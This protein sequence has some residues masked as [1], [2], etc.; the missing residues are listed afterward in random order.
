MKKLYSPF[1]LRTAFV[2][3]FMLTFVRGWGQYTGTGVFTKIT[4]LSELTDGYYVV[5][6]ETDA[7]LMTN[8]RSGS[9]TTG[10]FVSA[11]VSPT[12][13]SITNPSINNVWKI[14]TNG[15]GRT[16]YNEATLKYVGWS[17]GNAAS[18]EDT[19]AD[20][21]RWAFTYGSSKFTVNNVA[22]PVRQ[23]SYN[24]SAS[25]T[26]FAAY[27]NAGQD[28]LQL[29]KLTAT[30]PTI[31]VS[32]AL[33]GLDYTVGS[34]PSIAKSFTVTGTS[35]T[36]NIDLTTGGNFDISTTEGGTYT[37]TLSV[38]PANGTTQTFYARLRSGLSVA[39]YLG[40][41]N[42]TSTGATPK[43]VDLSGTVSPVVNYD[44]AYNGNGSTSGNVPATQTG[45]T[46]YTVSG[47]T[48]ALDRIGYFFSGWTDNATGTGTAYG[49]GFTTTTGTLTANTNFYAR[50][51][52]Y[53]IYQ[54]NGETGGAAPAAQSNYNSIT[55]TLNGV[56]TLVRTSGF[57]CSMR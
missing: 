14:E 47:N 49:P 12:T 32:S 56:G 34:G 4:S 21:N 24:G 46:S 8:G 41:V 7:V 27:G 33:T 19:P 17:S 23:L 39:N 44:L 38:A 20:T 9:A 5:T 50:W 48:G 35:L 18:I 11:S 55:T 45:A 52:Y 22:T 10:Y 28:E 16:I 2:L 1:C 13:G 40:S 6:N 26:R 53:V 43:S 25:P 36:A 15:S 54:G 42:I 30:T 51:E 37:S 31:T 29:Y 3:L 57:V